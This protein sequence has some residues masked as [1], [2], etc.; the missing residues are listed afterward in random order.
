MVNVVP[1]SWNHQ[2]KTIDIGGNS[3]FQL[4]LKGTEIDINN[5]S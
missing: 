2:A 4:G 5:L 3:K 1:Q